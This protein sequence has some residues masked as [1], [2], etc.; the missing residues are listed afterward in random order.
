[1]AT[2]FD[3][4]RLTLARQLAGLTKRDLASRLELSPA[5][6]TQFE[7]RR[8]TPRPAVVARMSLVLGYPPEYFMR[9]E[10]RRSPRPESRSFFRSLRSTRQWER[11][12]AEALAEHVADVVALISED[13]ELPELQLPDCGWI[14]PSATRTEIERAAAIVRA[15][16]RLPA[17]P[18]GH[19]V[20]ELEAH[21]IL[22]CRLGAE[23]SRLDAFSR[24]LDDRPLVVLWASKAD[25]ARSR[26]DA[27]HELGHLAMHPDPEAA[28]PLMERQAHAFAAALLMPAD[29]IDQELPRRPPRADD[30]DEL[31]AT[32]RRWGVSMAALFKRAHDLG[33]LTEASFR[34]AMIRL[35]ERGMRA[36][37]GD[38][39]GPPEAPGL[40]RHALLAL[41]EKRRASWEEIGDQLHFGGKRLSELVDPSEPQ[42]ESK[43]IAQKRSLYA[44]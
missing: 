8:T 13:F 20:R 3:P 44:V 24:W 18:V 1:L 29:Q 41:A 25:K 16:W 39:L 31:F 6:I 7:S 12:R 32:R 9:T 27:S 21:G 30:W 10:K 2:E 40:L 19:V 42:G 34:R 14:N 35:S 4:G 38:D 33:A 43:V 15:E 28:N 11:D 22:V 5:A 37:E 26:F 36:D 23:M 17:G